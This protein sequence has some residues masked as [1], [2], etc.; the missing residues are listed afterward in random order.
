MKQGR[1]G[2][3]SSFCISNGHMSSEK[4]VNW[5]A[6]HQKYKGRLVLRG[7]IVKRRFWVLRSIH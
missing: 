5:E 4:L 2:S 1:Q 3:Y 6:K 7:D